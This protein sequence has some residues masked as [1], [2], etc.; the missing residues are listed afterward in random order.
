MKIQVLTDISEKFLT[1]SLHQASQLAKHRNSQVLEAKDLAFYLGVLL[2]HVIEREWDFSL[3]HNYELQ[4]PNLV[5][6]KQNLGSEAH[7]AKVQQ[8]SRLFTQP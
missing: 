4:N 7:Q 8:V 6:S 5:L 3:S 2:I 1:Q